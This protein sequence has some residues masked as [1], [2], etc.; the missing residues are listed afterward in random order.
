M[1]MVEHKNAQLMG[2]LGMEGVA[3]YE[4]TNSSAIQKSEIP[5]IGAQ[6]AVAS[7]MEL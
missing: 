2:V 7:L 1:T 6:S 5:D 3:G 4:I